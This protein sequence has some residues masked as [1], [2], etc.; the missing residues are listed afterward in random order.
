MPVA[1][2]RPND[3]AF[4]RQDAC[5]DRARLPR[6]GAVL[7]E[8]SGTITNDLAAAEDLKAEETAA[9]ASGETAAVEA[10]PTAE[11]VF[12]EAP[13]AAEAPAEE[14]VADEAAPAE[15]AP[16]PEAPAP[17]AEAGEEH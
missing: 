7:A 2:Q 17:E 12:G 3:V 15:E 14:V 1:V 13:A 11:D 6:I 16:A 5:A 9:A 10:E 4:G 8:R